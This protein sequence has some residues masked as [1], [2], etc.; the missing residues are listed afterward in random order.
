[1]SGPDYMA[2]SRHAAEV[3]RWSMYQQALTHDNE[4]IRETVKAELEWCAS[5]LGYKLVNAETAA[6]NG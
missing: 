1:M 5:A 2:A 6:N 3:A 4:T